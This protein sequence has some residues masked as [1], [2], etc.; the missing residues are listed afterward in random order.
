LDEDPAVAGRFTGKIGFEPYRSFAGNGKVYVSKGDTVTVTYTDNI[1]TSGIPQDVS[2]ETTWT[3]GRAM[4][5]RDADGIIND[6]GTLRADLFRFCTAPFRISRDRVDTIYLDSLSAL[7]NNTANLRSFIADAHA[8]GIRVECLAG[9]PEWATPDGLSAANDALDD[10]AGF[11]DSGYA[12]ERFDGVHINVEPYV[13]QKWV[14]P[15]MLPKRANI[16]PTVWSGY[17]DMLDSCRTKVDSCNLA[18]NDLTLAADIP[19]WLDS[20]YSGVTS[21]DA[22]QDIVDYSVVRVMSDKKNAITLAAQHEVEYAAI[23]GKKVLVGV[24]TGCGA[25]A[26]GET[27]CQEGYLVMDMLLESAAKEWKAMK[28]YMGEA[29]NDYSGY[30]SFNQLPDQAA[31]MITGG[32][33]RR[34]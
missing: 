29:I 7:N 33:R 30:R 2:A 9:A 22:V 15:A 25:Y 4:W 16:A 3:S 21:S 13:F 19:S 14:S 17:I 28:S 34:R 8:S 20:D 5:V 10:L 1:T 12:N 11:N 18:G 32:F 24:E 31:S 6:E 23:S 27:F 26:P